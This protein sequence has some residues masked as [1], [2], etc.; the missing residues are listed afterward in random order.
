MDSLS[1]VDADYALSELFVEEVT[2]DIKW[3]VSEVSD[4]NVEEQRL[5]VVG[6]AD[7]VHIVGQIVD[8]WSE[9]VVL[10][11]EWC[12][13]ERLYGQSVCQLI[14]KIEIVSQTEVVAGV[15]NHASRRQTTPINQSRQSVGQLKNIKVAMSAIGHLDVDVVECDWESHRVHKLL[16][17]VDD[18]CVGQGWKL[19]VEVV[20]RQEI[21]ILSVV[22]CANLQNTE[23]LKCDEWFVLTE[24]QSITIDGW[25]GDKQQAIIVVF[26]G[27]AMVTTLSLAVCEV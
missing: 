20:S 14:I 21:Q 18:F 4:W 7:N 1:Q 3:L 17:D 6:D 10:Y 24:S 9:E 16:F 19:N 5:V 26:D 27:L 22:G 12:A 8:E 11:D 2:A 13:D 25:V 15:T 23:L